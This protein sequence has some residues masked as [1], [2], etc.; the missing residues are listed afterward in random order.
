MFFLR[1]IQRARL[2]AWARYSEEANQPAPNGVGW[3]YRREDY[4]PML[5][6]SAGSMGLSWQ[7]TLK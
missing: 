7:V 2:L 5:K 1:A 3:F 6:N 4:C